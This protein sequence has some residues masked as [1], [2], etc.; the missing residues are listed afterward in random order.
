MDIRTIRV[1]G[2]R[3]IRDLRVELD[4]VTVVVGANGA[5]KTNLYRALALAADCAHGGFLR[6][7]AHDGGLTSIHFA[8]PRRKKQEPVRV[9]LSVAYDDL[10]TRM[11]FGFAPPIPGGSAFDLDTQVKEE[12]V[13]PSRATERSWLYRRKA[14]LVEA[15]LDDGTIREYPGYVRPWE[16]GLAELNEP[17]AF[18]ELALMRDRLQQWRFY[19]HFRSDPESPLRASQPGYRSPVLDSDGANLAAT[20]QTIREIGDEEALDAAVA[21]AFE[22]GEAVVSVAPNRHFELR[23]HIPGLSRPLVPGEFSDGQLRYL[24]LACA[25]LSPRPPGFLVLNEPETSLSPATLEHLAKLIL[26]AREHS[27]IWLTTHSNTLAEALATSGAS[28]VRL[29]KVKGET[30]IEGEPAIDRM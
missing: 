17:G 6:T 20:F 22:G 12:C 29:E 30:R 2:Y 18:P 4:R 23:V 19:H 9:E 16:L 25:L 7:I 1:R 14:E 11:A 21:A 26:A 24:A 28:V 5:G 10:S 27:Q 3:S 13:W 8:G 15:R